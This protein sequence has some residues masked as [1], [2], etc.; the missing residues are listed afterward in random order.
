L[1]VT[2][3][4]N[5]SLSMD[6]TKSPIQ[7]SQPRVIWFRYKMNYIKKIWNVYLMYNQ[8]L[9]YGFRGERSPLRTPLKYAHATG[10]RKRRTRVVRWHYVFLLRLNVADDPSCPWHEHHWRRR[11]TVRFEAIQPLLY[12]GPMGTTRAQILRVLKLLKIKL[13][14]I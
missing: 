5:F 10:V 13:N 14:G 9:K 1:K 4:F 12:D 2:F 7:Y 8:S 6:P 11:G 3:L